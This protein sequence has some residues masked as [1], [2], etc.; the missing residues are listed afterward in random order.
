MLLLTC[1]FLSFA[2]LGLQVSLDA[3]VASCK[4]SAVADCE[5]GTEYVI[6]NCH[7]HAVYAVRVT[8]SASL[9][10]QYRIKMYFLLE[11]ELTCG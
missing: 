9:H 8:R 5:E 10:L 11:A 4:N 6:I 7:G 3:N 2:P 1:I